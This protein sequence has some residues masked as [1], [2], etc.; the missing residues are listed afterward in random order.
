VGRVLLIL[1]IALSAALLASC[2]TGRS[3]SSEA[4]AA[5]PAVQPQQGTAVVDSL[6][7]EQ[8]A[9]DRQAGIPLKLPAAPSARRGPEVEPNEPAA[10]PEA[11]AV[12]LRAPQAPPVAAVPASPARSQAANPRAQPTARAAATPSAAPRSTEAQG[13]DV[14]APR[15]QSPSARTARVPAAS[16]AQGQ[17]GTGSA[18][19]PASQGAQGSPSP[20]YGR[21][22]EVYA[23][24]G[25]DVQV[26]LDGVGFLFLGFP[27]RS[28]NGDGM[29]FEGK[30]TRDGKTWFSFKALALGTYNLDF[31]RQ[32]NTT[33][34]S[35]KE[36]VRVHVVSD[37]D[38][39]SAVARQ[40]QPQTPAAADAVGDPVFAAK[41]ASLGKYDAAIA[42]LLKGYRDGS[43]GLNDAI[44]Q[45]YLRTG[46][47]DAAAKYFTKNMAE[48][49]R[50]GDSAVLGLAS[51]AISQD[52]QPGLLSL[53]KRLLAVK[54]PGLEETLL[55]AARFEKE[56]NEAGLGI[57]LAG[58][59]LSRYP[60]GKRRDEADF[61]LGQL[62]ELDS[63]FR[64]LA[65][66][67][68]M[69][70]EILDRYPESAYA[71]RARIRVGY[72]DR[73]F[74]EIR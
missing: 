27:D 72:I 51:V 22:R 3:A 20:T 17:P 46:A 69:Y 18:S 60:D 47:Y 50:Y 57:D 40:D 9:R 10:A 49:G 36:T 12:P 38:F 70:K 56:K 54:D 61:L 58:E 37:A 66:A 63:Q 7:P 23:R 8:G 68:A 59:Y 43:P 44:A 48:Q 13:A 42:E 41:L 30:D 24:V 53:L 4:Q 65:R 19:A 52:D 55:A 67:R 25:D 33:G 15:R 1:R 16:P 6:P 21:L 39:A 73:H 2:A 26:S 74:F 5:E 62:L 29:S 35:S 71:A 28:P 34:T 14:G 32:D 45:L 64:D 11:D 31:L